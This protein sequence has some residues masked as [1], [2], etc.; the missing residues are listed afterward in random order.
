MILHKEVEKNIHKENRKFDKCWSI[1]YVHKC[2]LLQGLLIREVKLLIQRYYFSISTEYISVSH[3]NS[4]VTQ[5]V[6]G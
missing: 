1:L 4:Q 2:V 6:D 3:N 5:V